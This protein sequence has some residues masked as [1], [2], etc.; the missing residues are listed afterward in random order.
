[1]QSYQNL[2]AGEIELSFQE[3]RR[4]DEGGADAET[5]DVVLE[6]LRKLGASSLL[7]W[8]LQHPQFMRVF[9][10]FK[11][12]LGVALLV[13]THTATR[14]RTFELAESVHISLQTVKVIFTLV[15]LWLA[16]CEVAAWHCLQLFLAEK[17]TTHL[18]SKGLS[19][20]RQ[21]IRVRAT[22]PRRTDLDVSTAL[23]DAKSLAV[24]GSIIATVLVIDRQEGHSWKEA[25]RFAFT[26][27]PVLLIIVLLVRQF[28]HPYGAALQDIVETGTD[29]LIAEFRDSLENR[30]LDWTRLTTKHRDM[31]KVL[32]HVW[33]EC[34]GWHVL[35]V[36]SMR[37]C[38]A[39][40]ACVLVLAAGSPLVRAASAAMVC[41]SL[42]MKG[43]LAFRYARYTELCIKRSA[44]TILGQRSIMRIAMDMFGELEAHERDAH[45]NFML[46]LKTVQCGVELPIIGLLTFQVVAGYAKQAVT[47]VP[48]GLALCLAVLHEKT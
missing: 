20:I 40:A 26:E 21:L 27:E 17:P 5:Q 24:I 28:C 38:Y 4:R 12:A 37:A 30:T 9:L 42:I 43:M 11:I 13:V 23:F 3:E 25:F 29:C 31:D 19:P 41:M 2:P 33:H 35:L 34:Y 32:E 14:L 36:L 10:A 7:L 18:R 22:G 45:A 39:F 46:Y 8:Q 1:M 16:T 6:D 44:G 15:A 47:L 48:T